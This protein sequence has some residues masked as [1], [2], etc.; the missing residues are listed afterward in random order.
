MKI[1]DENPGSADFT[2]LGFRKTLRNEAIERIRP[3]EDQVL[4]TLDPEEAKRLV[5]ELRVQQIELEIQNEDLRRTQDELDAVRARYFDLYDCAPVGY[6]SVNEVGMILLANLTA[7]I[8]LGV[9]RTAL[10][11]LP[12]TRFILDEDQDIYYLH[13]KRLLETGTPQAYELRMVKTAETVF[14]VRFN[15]T[16]SDNSAGMPVFRIVLSDIT[17]HK[18]AEEALR[19]SRVRESENRYRKLFEQH[20]AVM[21]ILDAESGGIISANQAAARFYGWPLDQLK[22]MRI[23]EINVLP[24]MSSK[25]DPV[26][27]AVLNGT[28]TESRHRRADGA[29][30]DVE[31]FSNR[32]ESKEKDLFF[33]IVHDITERKQAQEALQDGER[34]L[35]TILQTT[36]DGFWVVDVEGKITEVNEAYCRMLG[37]TRDELL[38]LNVFAIDAIEEPA[39]TFE[40]IQRIITKGSEIF[41]TCQQ[42][43]DGSVFRVEISA[44]YM[45]TGRGKFV[46]FCRDITDRRLAEEQLH[47]LNNELEQRVEQR[48]RE[49]Q[50]SQSH[51][52]HAEKVSAIGKLS[53]SIAHEFNNPL[54]GIMS[55]LKGLKKRAILEEEDRDL[56]DAA[57]D[58]SERI[59]NLIRSLQ[60]FNRPSSGRKVAMDVQGS[61][62][63]LLLL[64]KSDFKSKRI[65]VVRNY[66]DSL[67]QILAVPDQIKQVFLNLLTNAADACL[68]RGGVIT[69]STRQ[70]AAGVAVAINDTGIGIDPAKM[71]LIFQPFYTTKP[72]VKGTG[73]GLSVC[74]GIVQKHRGEIRVESK[75]G[76][77]S[78][79][80]VLLPVKGE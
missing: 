73:L 21:L 24:S 10:I 2:A 29:I 13:H 9:P 18:K 14:W 11:K 79:F 48:T 33:S 22:R 4:E 67:P 35:R 54:Q 55:I 51:Y 50:E 46:C 60:D 5:H 39:Q 12:I 49:L 80:T 17:D 42:R 19:E 6:L 30:R 62:D 8:L 38:K 40:R 20:S 63:S 28:G 74:H 52:L 32:I 58:E 77:G 27:A 31:V 70:E 59:K 66:T 23:Q 26:Q 7:A 25:V 16:V 1:P 34:Y 64:C 3:S 72:E 43:K 78:T 47:A 68:Q 41:E 69:I 53:A 45:N 57:I 56:L 15:A 76:V 36:A 44:T 61:I 75:P 37:Y 71:D 65:S